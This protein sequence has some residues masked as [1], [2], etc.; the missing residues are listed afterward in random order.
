MLSIKCEIPT[1][2]IFQAFDSV[3][4]LAKPIK[5]L[6]LTKRILRLIIIVAI[7]FLIYETVY[8]VIWETDKCIQKIISKLIVFILKHAKIITLLISVSTIRST[9]LV[10]TCQAI[11]RVAERCDS[12]KIR[13]LAD[14]YPISFNAFLIVNRVALLRII[15]YITNVWLSWRVA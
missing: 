8:P 6:V 14:S 7:D 12:R 13:S 9:Y 2:T 4:C 10:L 3:W 15:F 11:D 1:L 5:C